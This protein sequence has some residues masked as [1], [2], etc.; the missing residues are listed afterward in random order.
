MATLAGPTPAYSE[1]KA[2]SGTG[3]HRSTRIQCRRSGVGRTNR[4]FSKCDKT[5]DMNTQPSETIRGTQDQMK[6]WWKDAAQED[7]KWVNVRALMSLSLLVVSW[8]LSMPWFCVHH[9]IFFVC[10]EPSFP[11]PVR[12]RRTSWCLV[13]EEQAHV[14]L[15][16][17]PLTQGIGATLW[18][19]DC[20]P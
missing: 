16:S 19:K 11:R 7:K 17:F 10:V 14:S 9:A 5:W 18:A 8:R 12:W 13:E 2:G 4:L 6:W 15:L 3:S 1:H 20:A